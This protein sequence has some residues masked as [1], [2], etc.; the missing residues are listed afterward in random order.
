MNQELSLHIVT[1]KLPAGIN[2]ISAAEGQRVIVAINTDQSETEQAAA[3][4]HECLH[5]WHDDHHSSR[6]VKEIERERREEL[7]KITQLY[8][9]EI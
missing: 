9:Q 7:R 5:I 4:L 3:F 1:D 8:L 2:G 6:A